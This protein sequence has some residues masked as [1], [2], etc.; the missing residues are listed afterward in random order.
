MN[1]IIITI[2]IFAGLQVINVILNSFKSLIMAKYDSATASAIIN[3]VT[4]GF[5]TVIVQ[6]IAHLDLWLTVSVTVITNV[7]GVYITYAIMAKFK[8]DELWKIEI[9]VPAPINFEKFSNH[10][11]ARLVPIA[12]TAPKLLTAYCYNQKQTEIVK[13]L[14]KRCPQV[15]FNITKVSQKF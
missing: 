6:Q 5:Y 12:V 4:F 15:K 7:I 13:K 11:N 8:K 1:E 3:A 10:L 9:Y 2:L 14:C